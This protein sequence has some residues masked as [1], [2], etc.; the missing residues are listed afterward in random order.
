MAANR[1]VVQRMTF[2][3][4]FIQNFSVFLAFYKSTTPNRKPKLLRSGNNLLQNRAILRAALRKRND[5][6][7]SVSNDVQ[8]SETL[9]NSLSLNYKSAALPA[10]LCQR[11][12]Y[13]SCFQRV[14]LDKKGV[15]PIGS[16]YRDGSKSGFACLVLSTSYSA[17]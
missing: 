17:S 14:D 13:E 12:P 6:L 1:E 2:A 5:E 9:R 15:A 7:L 3:K 8:S 4:E 10:K 11:S 16:I